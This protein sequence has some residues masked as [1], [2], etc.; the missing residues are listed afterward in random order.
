MQAM[1]RDN[2]SF[3]NFVADIRYSSRAAVIEWIIKCI[4]DFIQSSKQQGIAVEDGLTQDLCLHLM[5]NYDNFPFI[6]MPQNMQNPTKGN[7]PRS[8]F[9]VYAKKGQNY[10]SADGA[11]GGHKIFMEFEAKRLNYKLGKSREKEYVIGEYTSGTRTNNSGGIER[12]KNETHG[13]KV[14]H[15]GIIGYLQ[16]HEFS[17]WMKSVNDWIDAEIA[18]PSDT[19]LDWKEIDRLGVSD[20]SDIHWSFESTAT[21]VSQPPISLT[22]IW[23]D[24]T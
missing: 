18:N 16:D 12:Y 5:E 22:H 13:D 9:G 17:V 2:S 14:V 10:S 6:F 19:N 1:S 11:K 20:R 4:P 8:D 7:S 23:I 3:G 24:L 21:R 15:G